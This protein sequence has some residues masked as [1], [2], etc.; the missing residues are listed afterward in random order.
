[1]R[2][3][4]SVSTQL[5]DLPESLLLVIFAEYLS[6]VELISTFGSLC[7]Y[8]CHVEGFRVFWANL[9]HK[10]TRIPFQTAQT[11]STRSQKHPRLAY[12]NFIR[13]S[14]AR[15]QSQFIRLIEKKDTPKR[16]RAILTPVIFSPDQLA[17][18]MILACYYRRIRCVKALITDF[19]AD[20]NAVSSGGTV[21]I[22]SAWSG[23]LAMV[24]WLIKLSHLRRIPLRLDIK[25][26]LMKTSSCGGRGPF[27]AKEWARRKAEVCGRG[28]S[29]ERCA[30]AI[31][32]EERR[33]LT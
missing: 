33:Q 32:E 31:E 20:Y 22:V 29:H 21:L 6:S 24:R 3:S 5:L 19:N 28:S 27:T 30:E 11:R 18:L 7:S 9:Y 17:G 15:Q 14:W 25:G 13:M 10:I 1:M 4:V 12:F 26:T 2:S 8:V 16:L 23:D